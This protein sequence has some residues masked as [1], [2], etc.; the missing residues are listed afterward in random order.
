MLTHMKIKTVFTIVTQKQAL[1]ASNS[2]FKI[3]PSFCLAQYIKFIGM[4]MRAQ[5][6]LQNMLT[7]KKTL[8]F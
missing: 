4:S 8:Q 5:V 3:S 6:Q 7:E 2:H 1:I